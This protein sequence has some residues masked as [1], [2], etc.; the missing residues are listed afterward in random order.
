[1]SGEGEA[2][3]Y[4]VNRLFEDRGD[5]ADLSMLECLG[6]NY[7]GGPRRGL[8]LN[9]NKTKVFW[10]KEDP[11]S[12]VVGVFPPNI[13]LPM[14]VVKLL[15]DTTSVDLDFS[16]ELA[17]RRVS[18]S[19]ELIDVVTK[20]NDPWCELLLLRACIED[21][22]CNW[23]RMTLIAGLGQPMN[24]R[25]YQCVI[26]YLLGFP[27]FFVP[28]HVQLAAG[29]L[30]GIFMRIMLYCAVIV[31]IKHRHNVVCDTL[32]DICFRSRILTC[33]EV[34]IGLSGGRDKPLHLAV[35]LLYS[36]DGGLDVCVNLTGSSPLTQT[37]MVDFVPDHV[38]IK[39]SQRK[40][41]KY[42]AKCAN[43]IQ[44]SP[45]FYLFCWGI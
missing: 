11:R 45:I 40:R 13:S 26:C 3:L 34:D 14:Y 9:V 35:M 44:F 7:A 8:H 41:V 39:A 31:G 22:T 21:H 33:K 43:W 29:S 18:R 25:T 28:N 10:P 17:L 32:V 12:R 42:E 30:R 2:I 5:N 23:L 6:D 20:L 1:V 19:I 27:L 4:V 37:G 24:G 16:S 36:G 15:C 38:V